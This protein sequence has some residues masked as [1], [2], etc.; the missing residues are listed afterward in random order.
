VN[1]PK[2]ALTAALH[3]T[4]RNIKEDKN[5][6]TRIAQRLSYRDGM[7]PVIGANEPYRYLGVMVTASLEWK[8]QRTEITNK[9]AESSRRLTG[10]WATMAQQT[11][12]M[13]EV[14]DAYR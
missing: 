6:L 14:V 4:G 9:V 2:C 12:S 3:N 13:R 7:I 8:H 10:S 11:R 1:V 5:T